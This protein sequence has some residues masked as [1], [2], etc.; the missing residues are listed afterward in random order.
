MKLVDLA[1]PIRLALTGETA[2]PPIFGIM[3]DLGRETTL[4]RLRIFRDRVPRE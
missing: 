3:A 4:R 2:S 1:Q